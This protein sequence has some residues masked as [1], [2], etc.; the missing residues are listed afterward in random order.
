M[1]PINNTAP[2]LGA[3]AWLE[4]R[5]ESR[6]GGWVNKGLGD[7]VYFR[8][9]QCDPATQSSSRRIKTDLLS[10]HYSEVKVGSR[11]ALNGHLAAG[12]H[13]EVPGI[14]LFDLA[15]ARMRAGID[16]GLFGFKADDGFR[17]GQQ[18][19]LLRIQN[20][21]FISSDLDDFLCAQCMKYT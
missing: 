6:C 17:M 16:R 8:A 10:R 19:Q 1:V 18:S 2:F 9:L 14:P 3:K 7:A 15:C 21:H 11:S 4:S 13:P 20:I 5:R 12:T